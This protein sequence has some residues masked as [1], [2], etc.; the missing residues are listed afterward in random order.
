MVDFQTVQHLLA[1]VCPYEPEEITPQKHLI[2]DLE[3][4][5]FGLMDMIISFEKE[6]GIEIPDKDLRLFVTVQDVIDYV[7]QK[8]LGSATTYA[9]A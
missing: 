7:E 2:S 9:R 5:S 1:M 6:F 4:D 8:Q 3:L